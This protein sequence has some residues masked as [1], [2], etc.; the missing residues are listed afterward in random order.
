MQEDVLLYL[1]KSRRVV[2][3]VCTEKIIEGSFTA[4]VFLAIAS[5]GNNSCF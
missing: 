4:G 2:E 3:Y 5:E 1:F